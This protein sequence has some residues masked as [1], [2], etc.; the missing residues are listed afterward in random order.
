V[1][2]RRASEGLGS[3]GEVPV[4]GPAPVARPGTVLQGGRAKAYRPLPA[5][6]RR[7]AYDRALEAYERGD[8]FLTHELLEPAWMGTDDPAERALHQGLIKL[9]A[10]FVHGVR[11]NPKGIVRNL[12]GARERLADAVGT[13]AAADSGLDVAA[14][15]DAID[16]RLARLAADPADASIEAP[17]LP[18]SAR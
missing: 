18:R 11:G 8:F 16:D 14:L 1:I 3:A 17:E 13:P 7:Q 4:A 12:V 9:A 15:L 5:A 10:A 6:E 2:D